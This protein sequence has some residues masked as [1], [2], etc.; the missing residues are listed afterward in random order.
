MCHLVG[1]NCHGF[2]NIYFIGDFYSRLHQFVVH[3]R[4]PLDTHDGRLLP[5]PLTEC[6]VYIQPHMGYVDSRIWK[7]VLATSTL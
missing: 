3:I 4:P 1:N 5:P 7:H 2:G 6:V